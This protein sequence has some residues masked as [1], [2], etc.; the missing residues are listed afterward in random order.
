MRIVKPQIMPKFKNQNRDIKKDPIWRFME[1]KI[2]SEIE[3]SRISQKRTEKLQIG[4]CC[5]ALFSSLF[6]EK[7]WE[8]LFASKIGWLGEMIIG[9][10]RPV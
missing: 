6:G 4:S 1:K 9:I 5:W 2:E 10:I 7:T 3:E 8:L